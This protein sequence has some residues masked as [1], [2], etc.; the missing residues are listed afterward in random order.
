MPRKSHVTVT[1]RNLSK[2]QPRPQS[3]F[4]WFWR[5]GAN[6]KAREKRPGDE[7]VKNYQNVITETGHWIHCNVFFDPALEIID[8]ISKENA[9]KDKK[10]A[11][12]REPDFWCSFCL[13]DHVGFEICALSSPLS[14]SLC[15]LCL[16]S[17]QDDGYHP[18]VVTSRKTHY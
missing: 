14:P 13:S 15:Y 17:Q 8:R 16:L 6:C 11:Q 12:K 3:A 7:V 1:R 9:M 5:W 10:N 2:I 18:V 4:L